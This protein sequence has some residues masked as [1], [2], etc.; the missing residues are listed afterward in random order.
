MLCRFIIFFFFA[1]GTV[2][3]L[4]GVVVVEEEE[5][6]EVE[7]EV[8]GGGGRKKEG[9]KEGRRRHHPTHLISQLR[10][11]FSKFNLGFFKFSPSLFTTSGFI[12]LRSISRET[13]NADNGLSLTPPASFSQN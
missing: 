1:E 2:A 5:V 11:H 12:L 4:V 13:E 9:R 8:G 7:E 10:K 3:L 6:E